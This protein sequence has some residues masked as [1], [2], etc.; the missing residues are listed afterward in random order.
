MGLVNFQKHVN[1]NRIYNDGICTMKSKKIFFFITFLLC[2]AYSCEFSH[3][4]IHL[5]NEVTAYLTGVK[6]TAV[7]KEQNGNVINFFYSDTLRE[8]IVFIVNA[9]YRLEG[10]TMEDF[11]NSLEP[12]EDQRLPRVTN[13]LVWGKGILKFN[14]DIQSNGI[15]INANDNILEY[16]ELKGR[17]YFTYA[18]APFTAHEIRMDKKYFQIE[19]G[20]YRIYAAWENIEGKIFEDEIEVYF[21]IN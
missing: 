6:L 19:D 3:E 17:Y 12:G 18:I 11:D 10:G 14:K 4:S 20:F 5:N 21:D 9:L 1:H 13:P 16:N 15:I 2:F 8:Q 7:D